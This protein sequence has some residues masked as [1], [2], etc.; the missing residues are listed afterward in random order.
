MG[1]EAGGETER[2]DGPKV[3][4]KGRSGVSHD[5][6]GLSLY[7]CPQR[8]VRSLCGDSWKLRHIKDESHIRIH[9]EE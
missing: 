2:R 4:L 8:Q 7:F 6:T 9:V 1:G 3:L 5:R